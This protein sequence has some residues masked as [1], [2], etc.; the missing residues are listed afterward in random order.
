MARRSFRRNVVK[1]SILGYFIY[2]SQQEQNDT[3]QQADEDI[4]LITEARN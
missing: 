4:G 1:A 2:M 3:D